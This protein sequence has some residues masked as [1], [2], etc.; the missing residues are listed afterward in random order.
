MGR[1]VSVLA[2]SVRVVSERIVWVP[3]TVAGSVS[4]GVV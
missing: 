3:D 1:V 4:D 2:I